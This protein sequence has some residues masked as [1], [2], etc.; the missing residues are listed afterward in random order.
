MR[1]SVLMVM[2][3]LLSFSA[4][5]AEP[6]QWLRSGAASGANIVA[7]SEGGHPLP[8][9]RAAYQNAAHPGK[10]VAGKCNIGWGGKEVGVSDYEVLAGS[11]SWRPRNTAGAFVGGQENGQ[12]MLLCAARFQG[13]LHPGKV[14]AG[15]CNI[16]YGGNEQTI[17][18][19]DVFV[20]A[21]RSVESNEAVQVVMK[22]GSPSPVEVYWVTQNGELSSYGSLAAGAQ[23]TQPTYRGHVWAFRR[24]NQTLGVHT[25]SAE[26]TQFAGVGASARTADIDAGP[27]MNQQEAEAKCPNVC[28]MRNAIWTGGW[29]TTQVGV[30]SVCAC[31]GFL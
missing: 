8:V 20:P 31:K 19:Y 21:L 3:F 23:R 2:G 15:R 26:K 24:G 11:G 18:D 7:G 30:M 17:D 22:N 10:V 9:C 12:P 25:S 14:V 6:M 13:G 28:R 29:S 1:A 4:Y 5:A 16:G 27:L